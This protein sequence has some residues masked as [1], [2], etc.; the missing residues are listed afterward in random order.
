MISETVCDA[1]VEG[2]QDGWRENGW[3]TDNQVSAGDG[4]WLARSAAW[5]LAHLYVATREG[6]QATPRCAAQ[7]T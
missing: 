5:P 7:R 3:T 6:R 2:T 1:E 4:D